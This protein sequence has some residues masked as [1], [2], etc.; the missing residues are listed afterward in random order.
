MEKP[1]KQQ[2]GKTKSLGHKDLS[3]EPST[4]EYSNKRNKNLVST[5][6]IINIPLTGKKTSYKNLVL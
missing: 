4:M 1:I 6:K 5:L 3:S 2:S